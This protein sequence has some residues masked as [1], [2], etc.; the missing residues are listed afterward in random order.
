VTSPTASKPVALPHA[1][2]TLAARQNAPVKVD[3]SPNPNPN[4]ISY[5]ATLGSKAQ[6]ETVQI[7]AETLIMISIDTNKDRDSKAKDDLRAEDGDKINTKDKGEE[8][9]EAARNNGEEAA[10][11][12]VMLQQVNQA[13]AIDQQANALTNEMDNV[14]R[15]AAFAQKDPEKSTVVVMVQEIK[16]SIEIVVQV[17][18]EKEEKRK[19]DASVYKQ[20]AMVANRGKQETETVMSTYCL[21]V[22]LKI[23]NNHHS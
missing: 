20:E 23:T 17:D 1:L 16:I 6:Q 11:Q 13:L 4:L 7:N 3:T 15:M 19:V 5:L 10:A 21:V 8:N 18:D 9:V 14:F 2:Q 22:Q 12:Q